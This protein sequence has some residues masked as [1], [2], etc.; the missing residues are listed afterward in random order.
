M[1][2]DDRTKDSGQKKRR[3]GLLTELSDRQSDVRELLDEV[4]TRE[5]KSR[6]DGLAGNLGHPDEIVIPVVLAFLELHRDPGREITVLD[7]IWAGEFLDH[8]DTQNMEVRAKDV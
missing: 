6:D 7:L 8:L 5:D 4:R 3:R 1:T 2:M